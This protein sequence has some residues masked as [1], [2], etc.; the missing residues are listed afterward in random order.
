MLSVHKLPAALGAR[1]DGIDLSQPLESTVEA[2]LRSV[3]AEHQVI[4]I[5]KQ[6]L[7]PGQ[8]ARFSRLFGRPEP[9]VLSHL[10]HPDFPEILP[11]SNVFVDGEPTGVY[12]GAAYWHTD[13]SYEEV[14]GAV[15]LVHCLETP[16]Q[17]GDTRFA[18]MFR[19]Y[20]ALPEATKHR[21]DAMTVLHHY[22]NRED[23]EESSRTSAS[24][25]SEEQKRR[26]KNVYHPLVMAHPA[27]GRKALY[28]VAGASFG[29]VGL[30][31]DEAV[32]L[33][34]ELKRHATRDEFVY[35]HRYAVGEVVAWD[36]FSTLHA[37]TLIPPATGP[38]DTRLLHRIS[39]K[40]KNP[41]GC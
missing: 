3:L 19:A 18:N 8:F 15:T 24:P 5:P 1:I 28:G 22:G 32:A 29:I 39:V 26:T 37:A 36:N 34:N 17:G 23:L 35:Q 7:E 27:T 40:S 10:R 12:D 41:S 20:E 4:V 33:L 9:H 2:Q 31:D 16:A 13:M 38:Q 21:I 30:P 25:L 6:C 14:P 11:L